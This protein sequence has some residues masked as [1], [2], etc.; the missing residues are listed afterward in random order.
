MPKKIVLGEKE[1]EYDPE[2]LSN[3]AKAALT[4]LQFTSMRIQEISNMQA[5]M[6]RDIW[7][8]MPMLRLL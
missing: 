7:Q 8:Q 6:Q 4:S 3:T 1:F 2:N 5:L